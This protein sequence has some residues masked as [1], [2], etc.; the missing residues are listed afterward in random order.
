MGAHIKK[1]TIRTIYTENDIKAT[2]VPVSYG[3][4][5]VLP[6]LCQFKKS[7]PDISLDV[8][9]NE[10]YVDMIS[11]AVDVSIRSGTLADSSLVAQ[12]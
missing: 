3:Q 2:N 10:Q 11:D 5:Y 4:M 6:M 9:F 12:N 8:S 1:R 7:Y